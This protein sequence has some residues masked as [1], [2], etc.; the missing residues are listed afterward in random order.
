MRVHV[1]TPDD[2]H[3][4]A[5]VY[6]IDGDADQLP[7]DVHQMLRGMNIE[8]LD[9]LPGTPGM[10]R[11]VVNAGDRVRLGVRIEP[12]S[13]DLASALDAPGTDGVLV[14]SVIDDTPAARA[15]IKAG[16]VI[17]GVNNRGV[18]NA[19]ELQKALRDVDGRV[20]IS[21]SRNG[22]RRTIEA[23]QGSARTGRGEGSP[24]SGRMEEHDRVIRLRDRDNG[25]QDGLRK[26]VDELRQQLRELRQ[27][28]EEQRD[29]R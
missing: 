5:H 4:K 20:S 12:L 24:G 9:K 23:E 29:H 18:R 25:S 28:L 7:P 22:S 1:V 19:E 6:R 10:R 2:P 3:G 13:E 21:V 16:D 8:G 27:Q 14:L 26:E 15:G 17:T 11:I